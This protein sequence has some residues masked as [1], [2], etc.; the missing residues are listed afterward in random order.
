VTVKVYVEGGGEHNKAL[1]T[2]CRKG[3]RNFFERAG[4]AGRMPRVVACGGR[5][6]AYESF[7]TTHELRRDEF[8]ML[9][10]DSESAVSAHRPW[11]HVRNR[12]EDQWEC[13]TGASEDQIH[14]M[15]M[16]MEAWFHSDK[17]AL[18]AYYG[19]CFRRNALSHHENIERIPKIDIFSGLEQ[20]TRHCETW[21]YSK[22]E[23]SFRILGRIDP[24]RVRNSSQYAERLLQVL[25]RV[26]TQ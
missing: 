4:L 17:D 19:K 2:E 25:E 18:E 3:F 12:Q 10:V 16:T 14:F 15:V 7:K 26:C 11:D 9:L 13:P 21:E 6:R 24:T 5:R 1:Q 22:G 20:A 8:P 23:D